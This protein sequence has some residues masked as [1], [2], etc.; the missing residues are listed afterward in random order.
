M[1]AYFGVALIALVVIAASAL[2]SVWIAP[3]IVLAA[4]AAF[5]LIRALTRNRPVLTI[6]RT[7]TPEPTGRPRPARGGAET[8]NERVGQG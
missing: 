7:R 3:V 5:A 4:L 6:E 2:V 1:P 8:T